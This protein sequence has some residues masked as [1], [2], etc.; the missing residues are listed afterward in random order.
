MKNCDGRVSLI[1]VG[2]RMF[3]FYKIQ[4]NHKLLYLKLPVPQMRTH[5]YGIRSGNVINEIKYNSKSYQNSFSLI[6]QAHR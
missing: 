3:H 1:V 4:N 2:G 6:V 5:L